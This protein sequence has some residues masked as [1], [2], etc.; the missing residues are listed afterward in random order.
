MSDIFS[1][2]WLNQF[3]KEKPVFKFN[4]IKGL[5]FYR[6][7]KL[8][9][10]INVG[11]NLTKG[12]S[13]K[14]KKTEIENLKNSVILI[15]DVP[16]YFDID[17]SDLPYRLNIHRIKQYPGYLVNLKKYSDLQDYI[18]SIFSN[19]TRS[20]FKRYE[21]RLELC[22]DISYKMFHGDITKENYEFIFEKFKTLL[23][24]RF[25]DK[26]ITNN[27]L[28]PNEWAFYHDVAYPMILEKKAALFVVFEN[29][30]PI[31][32][33]FNYL[34]DNIL[35]HAI[36]VFDTDYSKFHLGKVA[37]LNLF[38]WCFKNSIQ[39]FD[40][41][42]GH[43]DYKTHWKDKC[44]DF[45]Y[46]VYYNTTSLR[47]KITAFVILNFFLFKQF[48]RDR[49][50][51]LIL[52]KLTYWFKNE[53]KRIK[54]IPEFRFEEITQPYKERDLL[55]ID[56]PSDGL[57]ALKPAANEFLFLNREK[58]KDLDIF[59]LK[60]DQSNYILKGKK[61]NRMLVVNK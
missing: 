22:F 59:Q 52:H 10:Y 5:R 45:D 24:K 55:K 60:N 38:S 51:N 27:N 53:T 1:T 12:I 18:Q 58:L 48:L 23:E 19:K 30:N 34:S 36:T 4:F 37:L 14:L 31:A 35:F 49:K 7:S 56:F 46:H 20:K 32:I 33:T 50:V 6:S 21:R 13:Y 17:T 28:N 29:S 9:I 26:Q 54:S 40:F 44:Y 11:R 43:F 15:Y 41:S 25:T 3:N 42:K 39:V 61:V 2:K 47:S 16:D 8:P 57:S